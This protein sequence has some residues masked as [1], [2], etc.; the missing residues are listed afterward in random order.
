L[1]VLA[2][3]A[4]AAGVNAF[5]KEL[6]S[7]AS[8]N[9]VSKSAP[10]IY[11]TSLEN[12]GPGPD[13]RPVIT[14]SDFPPN[15]ETDGTIVVKR[16]T[17]TAWQTLSPASGLGIGFNPRVKV[18]PNGTI[19]VAWLVVEPGDS[20]AQVH[21]RRRTTTS[22]LWEQLS[23]SDSPGGLTA[24]ASGIL[25]FSLAV[26]DDG[27]PL[28]AFMGGAQTGIAAGT[29]GILQDS[30]Q[31]YVLKHT[32]ASGWGYL[33]SGPATG[34]TGAS[35]ARS[36][37]VNGGASFAVHDV[38]GL[39]LAV[40]S[41][42]AP[43]V[44]FRYRTQYPITPAPPEF[45]PRPGTPATH[46]D[47]Y[48]TRYA[49]NSSAWTAV[50]PAV[51][52]SDDG[53][54]GRGAPS[55]ISNTVHEV[56]NTFALAADPNSQR[57]YLAWEIYDATINTTIYVRRWNGVDTWEELSG[58]ATG[59]GISGGGHNQA[60]AVAVDDDG[61][62]IVAWQ[63]DVLSPPTSTGQIFVLRSTAAGG[64]EEMGP[65]SAAGDGI[66]GTPP[67]VFV[68]TPAISHFRSPGVSPPSNTAVLWGISGSNPQFAQLYL[69]QFAAGPSFLLSV[70]VAGVG[71]VVS[72]PIGIDC[73]PDS[74]SEFFP[75]GQVV[76][77]TAIPGPD[78]LFDKWTGACIGSAA[79]NVSVLGPRSLNASFVSAGT[80]TVSKT[81]LGTVTGTGI[82]CGADCEQKYKS[83]T[84][85][86]LTAAMPVGTIFDGWGG[87]CLFRGTNT[88]CPLTIQSNI[89]VS[90]SFHQRVYALNV[91]VNTPP[92][93]VG[94]GL[95]GSVDGTG[96]GADN[97]ACSYGGGGT[98]LAG[99][100]HGTPVT[101]TALAVAGNRFQ[102]WLG[103]PCAGRTN[104]TCS[105]PM[106]ANYTT[107]ALF[108]GVTAIT[109]NKVGN[110]AGV[111]TGP[112][113]N[114]GTDCVGE[115]FTNTSV[116]FKATPAVSSVIEPNGGVC[117]W[118]A[119]SCTY[120]T[121]GLTQTVNATF[122]LRRYLLN[123]TG[124][125]FG[126]TTSNDGG[127]DCGSVPG[128]FDC[129]QSYDH[130][131]VVALTPFPGTDSMF[132]SWTGCSRLNGSVCFVDMT[133]NHT[134]HKKFIP[135][136]TLDLSASGNG[137][138]KL[139]VPGKPPVPCTGCAA[140]FLLPFT[141]TAPT[142]VTATP[143]VGSNFQWLAGTTVNTCIGK[144]T[145]CSVVMSQNQSLTGV[146][147]LNRHSLTVM[148]RANGSITGTFAAPDPYD[149]LCGSG[150]SQCT[151]VQNYGTQVQLQATP[152]I[153]NIFVNWT[154]TSPCSVGTQ[155]TNPLCS[156]PLK[157]NVTITPNFR[158]RTL[159][160]VVKQG[161]G[162]GTITG[163]GITCGTDCSEAEFDGKPVTLTAVTAVGSRFDGFAGAC[164]SSTSPCTF[165]PATNGQNVSATFTLRRF[166]VNATYNAAGI[167]SNPFSQG[168][169]ISCGG[170]FNDCTA[171]LDYGQQVILEAQPDD[172]HVFAKWIGTVCNG[173]TNTTCSFKVPLSNVSIAPSYRLRTTVIVMKDGQGKGVV[174]ST[175]PTLNCPATVTSQCQADFF[176]GTPVTL[177]ATPAT[178]S[179][180]LGFSDQCTS[181]NS[182]CT[183]TPSGPTQFVH[184]EFQLLP[185]TLNVTSRNQGVVNSF[186]G[187]INCGVVGATPCS[188]VFDYGTSLQLFAYPDPGYVLVNWT[189]VT[190][191]GGN[192]HDTCA[193]T[194]TGNTTATPNYRR[195]TVVQV[196]RD[197]DG[198]GTVTG[199]GIACGAD[200]QETIFDGKT[201]AL[202]ATA[203]VGSR[204]TAWSAPC[205]GSNASVCTFTPV[206]DQ[207]IVT[208]N[209]DRLPVS[210]TVNVNG[211]GTAN[212]VA[213]PCAGASSPCVYAKLYGDQVVLQPAADAGARFI[214]W[215]G[216]T[217][218]A[219]TNCTV[220]LN[221]SKMVTANFQPEFTLTVTPSGN[222]TGTVTGT[223]IN[224][225]ADCSQAYLNGTVVTLTRTVPVGANFQ[226]LGDCA[227]RGTNT[228]CPLTMNQNHSVGAHFQLQ[229]FTVTVNK[230][231]SGQ[232]NV[233]GLGVPCDLAQ[234]PC[235][236]MLDYGT[237]LNLTADVTGVGSTFDGWSG[238]GCSGTGGC[239]LLVTTNLTVSA[240]FAVTVTVG[241]S[242]LR[243][244]EA[245]TVT[246]TAGQKVRWVW[247]STNHNVVSGSNA[248]PDNQFCSP[249][250]TSCATTA[251]TG[252]ETVYEHTFTTPGTY[253]YFCRQHAASGMT[254]TIV[255]IPPE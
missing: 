226:W 134:V 87:A 190:C 61:N 115:A 58:S 122:T 164:V 56:Y 68:S 250:D 26:A 149:V 7:S 30:L 141:S 208:A 247:G 133:A 118:T 121:T 72:N 146:F 14:Y 3:P 63:H 70:G 5:W 255:V 137:H 33:G 36:F 76:N 202:T 152:D 65:S 127:I 98:C 239:H 44:A 23:G 29:D 231:G 160:T 47:L 163:P 194:L 28:I 136:R 204:F 214:S 81:G 210:L 94:Q 21:L 215:T 238:G 109:V 101:L 49:A 51:P 241:P 218:V 9:G 161:N 165:V 107:T 200:C 74:C 64:W 85:V 100:E 79:C 224:C 192:T 78:T 46:S 174:T 178:G 19:Y 203:A 60:P 207:Q 153:G 84:L 158:A 24:N 86:T 16:W 105:F 59:D 117:T 34:G 88:T 130:G 225:G 196:Q 41:I 191:T 93:T 176:D 171:T 119:G 2:P 83:G 4:E 185:F 188:E 253:P 159:V 187:T 106:T 252:P 221:G 113:I 39:V 22:T 114:C 90:A 156:F 80:L 220:L 38:D 96:G 248:V 91:A 128:H 162:T 125:G 104:N 199:T 126:Y 244:F 103:V 181:T 211:S 43:T 148:N 95:V 140:S 227:F 217:S 66:S 209:F 6:G 15:T 31:V 99:V 116:T 235:T 212:G 73:P 143:D 180:F 240:A 71:R 168:D 110:G 55:G 102:S 230:S 237:V 195:R 50:G 254:G 35:N 138:G 77:L 32:P 124:E 251:L 151:T 139:L 197:G 234:N 213:P 57:L 13:G 62:A 157:G 167:V 144:S 20:Q 8:G 48:V 11:P 242:G 243:T 233:L 179:R 184:A 27:N 155:A 129:T 82:A 166:A 154:G 132:V 10:G 182:S 170:L 236:A 123:V 18:A 216:C 111:I 150:D 42:G 205:A 142:L 45:L 223:G 186:P 108:R 25:D 112:L 67:G 177:R 245:S 228:T 147:A 193:F 120:T 37:A 249:G 175:P 145:P 172:E 40:D 89:S 54:A 69:R 12:V 135:A 219:A 198:T 1:V 246:I 17:G 183:F 206:G 52:Q 201:L 229:Q 169:D 92:G 173:S 131:T 189:G 53:S 222:A 97:I 232:G 75:N